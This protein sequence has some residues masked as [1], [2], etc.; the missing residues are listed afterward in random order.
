MSELRPAEERVVRT[1]IE[2]HVQ[3]SCQLVPIDDHTWA[4]HGSIAVDGEVIVA[5][6]DDRDT[7]RSRPRRSPP[8]TSTERQGNLMKI[9]VIG[10]TGLIGSQVVANLQAQGTT[11]SPRHRTPG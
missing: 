1:L 11:Q 3:V 4:I 9:V 2:E 5:E 7:P 10:G 6:F 8:P